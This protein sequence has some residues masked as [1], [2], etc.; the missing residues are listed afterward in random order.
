MSTKQHDRETC[1]D[2][3]DCRLCWPTM[4]RPIMSKEEAA[5]L[6]SETSTAAMLPPSRLWYEP[7]PCG[8]CSKFVVRPLF[9]SQDATVYEYE[10]KELIKRYNNAPKITKELEKM[11]DAWESLPGGRRILVKEVEAWLHAKMKP[12]IDA[13]R[14]L[15]KRRIPKV[16]P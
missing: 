2:G 12:R 6:V 9:Y 14:R 5:E 4:N 11:V 10:A 1:E 16:Q 3:L 7:C 8:K 15:L 13:I